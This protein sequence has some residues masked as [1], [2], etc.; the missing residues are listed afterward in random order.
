MQQSQ[1]VHHPQQAAAETDCI[2]PFLHVEHLGARFATSCRSQLYPLS[3]AATSWCTICNIKL[4][5]LI[6]S[7]FLCSKSLHHLQAARS[8][9]HLHLLVQQL[10]A[11]FCN[12]LQKL[13]IASYFLCSLLG[14]PFLTS[15][16]RLQIVEKSPNYSLFHVVL[17]S[18]Q[19][20]WCGPWPV[21][22]L[23]RLKNWC[24]SA[25]IPSFM[26]SLVC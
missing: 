22:K 4:Q 18:A 21:P 16:R 12:K 20:H 23:H 3:C 26:K 2:F 14:A 25:L 10:G 6:A 17:Q 5:K 24:A 15:C 11:P 7:S 13:M 19:K 1:L 9:L 8:W